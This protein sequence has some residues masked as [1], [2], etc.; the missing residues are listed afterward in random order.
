[1]NNWLPVVTQKMSTENVRLRDENRHLRMLLADYDPQEVAALRQ[2]VTYVEH[3]PACLF[4]ENN[5]CTCG[6]EDLLGEVV[7]P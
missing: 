5:E 3:F 6:L 7:R 4:D 1:M 2:L